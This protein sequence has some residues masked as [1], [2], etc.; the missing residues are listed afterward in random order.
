MFHLTQQER[1]VLF[2]LAAVLFVGTLLQLSFKKYPELKDIVN[3]IDSDHIYH[4]IN[5]NTATAEDL[6]SLPYI[7]QYTA[8]NII[9]YRQE[10]G[11]FMSIKEI[12]N[13]KGIRDK[14]YERFKKYLKIK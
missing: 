11:S 10:H 14:N 8:Q 7:G 12:K 2:I 6:E 1:Y 4:K 9:K 5:L 13:V 3:L